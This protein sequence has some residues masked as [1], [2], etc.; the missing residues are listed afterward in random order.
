MKDESGRTW[1]EPTPQAL[2]SA[3]SRVDRMVGG[4][5]PDDLIDKGIAIHLRML[6]QKG[7]PYAKEDRSALVKAVDRVVT[8]DGE[9]PKAHVTSL[10]AARMI[11]FDVG[12]QREAGMIDSGDVLDRYDFLDYM[13]TR[14]RAPAWEKVPNVREVLM[15]SNAEDVSS[16]AAGDFHELSGFANE[17]LRV[18]AEV[19]RFGGTSSLNVSVLRAADLIDDVEAARFSRLGTFRTRDDVRAIVGSESASDK[20]EI[21]ALERRREFGSVVREHRLESYDIAWRTTISLEN[22]YLYPADSASPSLVSRALADSAFADPETPQGAAVRKAKETLEK[23]DLGFA[24]ER[25]AFG[26]ALARNLKE[27]GVISV[28]GMANAIA[29]DVAIQLEARRLL[30]TAERRE[31]GEVMSRPPNRGPAFDL[32]DRI[33]RSHMTASVRD[34][35]DLRAIASGDF[36]KASFEHSNYIRASLEKAWR[37][38]AKED[39]A[40]GRSVDLVMDSKTMMPDLE[41][42]AEGRFAVVPAPAKVVDPA[43]RAKAQLRIDALTKGP[44][45]KSGDWIATLAKSASVER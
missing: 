12:L 2:A 15:S 1:Q 35:D 38:G 33:S 23:A 29:Y 45:M 37:M 25:P 44:S 7:T 39:R 26:H 34:A 3:M 24:V 22:R 28:S 4:A 16:I 19:L 9:E 11:T 13:E 17:S 20:K 30:K 42:A 14:N 32:I 6:E 41:A 27:D 31:R 36:S 8:I 43:A 40:A 5:Q 10:T 21:D 18:G